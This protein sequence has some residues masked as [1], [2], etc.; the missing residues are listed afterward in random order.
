MC[1]PRYGE[2]MVDY[3]VCPDAPEIPYM[4]V[5]FLFEPFRFIWEPIWHFL[6]R[7]VHIT[8]SLFMGSEG[9][10]DLTDGR[11]FAKISTTTFMRSTMTAQADWR[12]MDDE[13]L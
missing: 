8:Y 5:T 9:V 7:F 1:P 6:A 11:H 2:T 13:M 12:M 10:L 3:G 4:T